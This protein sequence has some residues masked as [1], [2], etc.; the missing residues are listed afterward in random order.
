[1][2]HVQRGPGRGVP[3]RQG[4]P[5]S[6]P[7]SRPGI[8]TGS[9]PAPPT[10]PGARPATPSRNPGPRTR[11]PSAPAAPAPRPLPPPP[12]IAVVHFALD[13]SELPP[14][15][16][17]HLRAWAARLKA[18]VP[19]PRLGVTGHADATGTRAHN[20]RLSRARARSAA[21]LLRAEGLEIQAM[22]GLGADHPAA[23]GRTPAAR[24]LNRRA[25]IRAEG[26]PDD[27]WSDAP[28]S[29]DPW[30]DAPVPESPRRKQP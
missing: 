27:P 3:V 13:C 18:L 8:C 6:C 24:A 2:L 11:G 22:E 12:G 5:A 7:G 29:D 16:Q 17:A 30:S 26:L 20:R 4:L 14:Q 1:M 21:D 10:R 9:R 19:V 25:E 28:W 15:G 23:P